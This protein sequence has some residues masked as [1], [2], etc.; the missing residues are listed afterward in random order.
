MTRSILIVEGW[1]DKAFFE[2]LIQKLFGGKPQ[3]LGLD[4]MVGRDK[5]QAKDMLRS[6]VGLDFTKIGIARDI[7]DRSPQQEENNIRDNLASEFKSSVEIEKGLIIAGETKVIAIPMGLYDDEELRNLGIAQYEME[8]YLVKLAL[9]ESPKESTE[10]LLSSLKDVCQLE[11][12]KE[13]L[14]PLKALFKFSDDDRAFARFLMGKS[15]KTT[16]AEVASNISSKIETLI[17]HT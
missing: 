8:D 7:D 3:D 14:Q 9:R 6:Y 11:R 4:M 15:S 2:T 13:F 16:V 5:R 10:R 12:S 1:D 17:K